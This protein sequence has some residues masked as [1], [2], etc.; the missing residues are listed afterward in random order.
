M[1][2]LYLL[3]AQCETLVFLIYDISDHILKFCV[4]LIQKKESSSRKL[5]MRNMRKYKFS[6]FIDELELEL[7]KLNFDSLINTNTQFNQL[8]NTFFEEANENAPLRPTI[9]RQK[10]IK[11]KLWLTKGILKLIK[12]MF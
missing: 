8:A 6:N 3:A 10:H 9:R 5:L 11:L 7:R 12:V 4:I 2:V 1:S